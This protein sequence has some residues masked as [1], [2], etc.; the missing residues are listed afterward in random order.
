MSATATAP[1]APARAWL[2]DPA[3]DWKPSRTL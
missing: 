3:G 1:A 2:A